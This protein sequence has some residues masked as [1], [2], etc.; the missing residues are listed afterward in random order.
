MWRP[1]S[2][3]EGEVRASLSPPTMS[4]TRGH[5]PIDGSQS[6]N[7]LAHS[8]HVGSLDSCASWPPWH[9]YQTRR[10]CWIFEVDTFSILLRLTKGCLRLT[11]GC[12]PPTAYRLPKVAYR[13]PA[14]LFAFG[15][16]QVAFGL[17]R[18]ACRLRLT[19]YH[20]SRAS[21]A[22]RRSLTAFGLRLTTPHSSHD[23]RASAYS[24]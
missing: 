13:L 3:S 23:P 15:L 8:N 21:H 11:K 10:S 17:P 9:R 19:A 12:L 1:R 16:P 4:Q 6:T 7:P 14:S 20:R 22:Y 24:A 5:R 2:V 18:V